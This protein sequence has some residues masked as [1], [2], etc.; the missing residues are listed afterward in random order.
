MK[1]NK[2]FEEAINLF[3]DGLLM[4]GKPYDDYD[5]FLKE[6]KQKL[7]EFGEDSNYSPVDENAFNLF[8]NAKLELKNCDYA[9]TALHSLLTEHIPGEM[10]YH[11]TLTNAFLEDVLS[12]V[13]RINKNALQE[14]INKYYDKESNWL[15]FDSMYVCNIDLNDFKEGTFLG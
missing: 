6:Y 12:G 9:S 3:A 8:K 4:V 13:I 5:K 14:F 15:M 11:N 7:N 2:K 1:R 10:G